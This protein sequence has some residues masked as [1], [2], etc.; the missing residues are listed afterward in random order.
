LD[1]I[2]I[3]SEDN[4]IALMKGSHR[5]TT[6]PPPPQPIMSRYGRG[7]GRQ[8]AFSPVGRIITEEVKRYRVGEEVSEMTIENILPD[9][10]VLKRK[11]GEIVKIYLRSE[12]KAAK[13]AATPARN[14]AA[15]NVPQSRPPISPRRSFRRRSSNLRRAEDLKRLINRGAFNEGGR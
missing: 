12:E 6:A 15:G 3:L 7:H 10:V 5:E 11:N 14:P 2:I 8:P 9:H 1:G 13:E 4:R